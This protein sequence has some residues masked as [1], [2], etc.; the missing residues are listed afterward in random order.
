MST[1]DAARLMNAAIGRLLRLGARPYRPG[2]EAQYEALRAAVMDRALSAMRDA[3]DQ[4]ARDVDAEIAMRR[5]RRR[6]AAQ[7]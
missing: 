6:R 4:F 1:D 5:D 3:G 7:W 2:D